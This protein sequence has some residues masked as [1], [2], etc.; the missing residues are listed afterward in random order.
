MP[1]R[2]LWSVT[3]EFDTFYPQARSFIKA[4]AS[5]PVS[6]DT[7]AK[8][9]AICGECPRRAVAKGKTYCGACGCG[10]HPAAKITWK[11]WL[12]AATCPDGRWEI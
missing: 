12:K 7:R 4:H 5:G 9:L 1:W 11:A 3:W 6:R 10:T 2:V 8:R